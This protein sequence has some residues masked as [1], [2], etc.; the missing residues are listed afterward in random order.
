MYRLMHIYYCFVYSYI[1]YCIVSYGTA[2]DS[3]LQPLYTVHNNVLRGLT[4]NHSKY[5]KSFIRKL[6]FLK[7]KEYISIR[8][9]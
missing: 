2:C 7:N 4:F 3:A 8:A 5:R 1:Q 6:E 9:I